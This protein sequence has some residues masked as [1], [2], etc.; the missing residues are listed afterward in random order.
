M[1]RAIN[2]SGYTTTLVGILNGGYADGPFAVA[3][4]ILPQGIAV[5]GTD[6]HTLYI[7]DN[8]AVRI[9]NTTSNTVSTLAGSASLGFSDGTG[10]NANFNGIAAIAYH[11]ALGL[12][13]VTDSGNNVIRSVTLSGVVTTVAGSIFYKCPPPFFFSDRENIHIKSQKDRDQLEAKMQTDFQQL[14]ICLCLSI[15]IYISKLFPIN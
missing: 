13:F 3:S 11:I 2:Q 1:I 14:S 6:F 4:F 12:F 10:T 8:S 15:Y 9:V 5:A 7:A